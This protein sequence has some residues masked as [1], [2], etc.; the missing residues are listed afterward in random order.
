MFNIKYKADGSVERYKARLVAK[1][2]TQIFGIDFN[3]TFVLVAKL[4]TIRALISIA[5]NLNW[6]LYQLDVKNAFLN[7]NLDEEVYMESPPALKLKLVREMF[8]D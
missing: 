6:S 2:F 1:D 3:E 8:A 5:A 7:E 4:N